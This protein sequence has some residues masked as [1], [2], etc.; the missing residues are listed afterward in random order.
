MQPGTVRPAEHR[1]RACPT[2]GADGRGT[3]SH[4]G[5]AQVDGRAAPV[6]GIIQDAEGEAGHFCLHQDAKVITCRANRGF[7]VR[8][9]KAE[10]RRGPWHTGTLPIPRSIPAEEAEQRQTRGFAAN[11]QAEKTATN[12]LAVY[13]VSISFS[14]NGSLPTGKVCALQ[15]RYSSHVPCQE[16]ALEVPAGF[17]I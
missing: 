9:H 1:A 7:L 5:P 15:R 17:L 3:Y 8:L 13:S 4:E 16:A 14:G 12:R 10:C 11:F 2:T 6:H